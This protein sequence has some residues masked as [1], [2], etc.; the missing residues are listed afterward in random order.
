MIDAIEAHRAVTTGGDKAALR[1]QLAAIVGQQF[2]NGVEFAEVKP[3]FTGIKPLPPRRCLEIKQH[4]P[5]KRG[6]RLRTAEVMH[7]TGRD[8][9]A[10]IMN[11]SVSRFDRWG[12]F[13]PTGVENWLRL[14]LANWKDVE[15]IISVRRLGLSMSEAT[16][17][18]KI[19]REDFEA[20]C[21]VCGFE[22]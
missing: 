6:R 1:E 17:R 18:L 15:R 10:E 4:T 20:L 7:T 22:Y 2:P 3:I 16:L 21:T 8:L 12:E 9:L 19:K 11:C 5:R 13:V 14:V